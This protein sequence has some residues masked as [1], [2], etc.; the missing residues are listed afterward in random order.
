MSCVFISRGRPLLSASS[1]Y[2]RAAEL[3]DTQAKCNQV[4]WGE[5]GVGG[6]GGW[7]GWVEVG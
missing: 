2:S 6:A 5:W 7:G 3:D 4:G 1:D